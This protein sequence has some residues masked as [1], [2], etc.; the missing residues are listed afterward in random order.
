ML[1]VPMRQSIM[2]GSCYERAVAWQGRA[3]N[4]KINKGNGAAG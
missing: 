2:T 1:H 4:L 3:V